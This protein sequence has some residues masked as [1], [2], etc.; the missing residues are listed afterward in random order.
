MTTVVRRTKVLFAITRQ[1]ACG[2]AYKY[3]TL[4]R[5]VS[6]LKENERKYMMLSSHPFLEPF[7]DLRRAS[8]PYH[9]PEGNVTTYQF[10]RRHLWLVMPHFTVFLQKQPQCFQ[11]GI[12]HDFHVRL[13]FHVRAVDCARH[14][15]AQRSKKFPKKTHT[16]GSDE[17]F[18]ICIHLFA[19]LAFFGNLAFFFFCFPN[20]L[21]SCARKEIQG[22]S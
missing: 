11:L 21:E 18:L 9:H 22:V 15:F 13:L 3:G 10:I 14:A 4:N 1:L 17:V 5:W 16:P 19:F 12:T 8:Q 7:H 20:I 2:G 6:K